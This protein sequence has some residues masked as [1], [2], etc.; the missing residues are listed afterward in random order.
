MPENSPE[1]AVSEQTTSIESPPVSARP[2]AHDGDEPRAALNRL[3][4]SLLQQ[5]NTRF[6]IEYLRLRRR[7]RE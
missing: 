5:R 7:L 2:E 4:A 6:L 3:A 1:Q